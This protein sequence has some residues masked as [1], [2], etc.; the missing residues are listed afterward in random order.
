ME[1][2]ESC[3]SGFPSYVNGIQLT[4]Q[5]TVT[6]DDATLSDCTEAFERAAVNCTLEEVERSCHGIFVGTLAEGEPCTDVSECRRDEGPTICK[7]VQSGS[8][9]NVGVCADPGRGTLGTPCAQSCEVGADCS[10]TSISGDDTAPTALCYEEDGLYCPIGETCAEV[11]T[12]GVECTWHE[13]CGSD[14]FCD[15]N[16]RTLAGLGDDCDFNWGCEAGLMCDG[17]EC[18]P[19]PFVNSYTCVGQPPSID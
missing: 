6:L 16:C 7:I 2:L 17:G 14:G 10:T 11:V 15:S 4:Q 18:V 9:P 5:G 8:D 12:D 3:E 19:E 1:A 13:A